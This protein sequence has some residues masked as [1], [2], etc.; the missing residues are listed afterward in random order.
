MCGSQTLLTSRERH[1]LSGL[2]AKITVANTGVS[3]SQ[4]EIL[5]AKF[6]ISSNWR[7]YVSAIHLTKDAL[8]F[9]SHLIKV[10]NLVGEKAA[11]KFKAKPVANRAI[12]I[13]HLKK[14][15]TCA[16]WLDAI[17]KLYQED[18]RKKPK[19]S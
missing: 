1:R 2:L 5:Q 17:T 18:V 13:R 9:C 7:Y 19:E 6:F 8:S 3:Y 4:I 16:R 12:M 14:C 10:P 15:R 11:K